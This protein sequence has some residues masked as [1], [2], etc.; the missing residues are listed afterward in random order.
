MPEPM[1]TDRTGTAVPARYVK[2][3]DKARDKL[4]RRIE[5]RW[6]E[7]Y[8][9]LQAVYA[10]TLSDIDRLAEL[11]GR[12]GAALGGAKGNLQ[13]QSFDG[14][15]EIGIDARYDIAF[16][17]RLRSAQEKI[18]AFIASKSEGID[19]ELRELVMAA[20]RPT[21]DGLLSR[22]RILGLLRLDI[23]AALWRE[24]MDLIRES[25][26]SRRGKTLLRVQRRAT[27]EAR[28]ERINLSM[29]DIAERPDATQA[30]P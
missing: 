1:M 29:S 17:E 24:A 3:Y 4:A 12:D 9:R 11:A 20:F 23:K 25:I 27:R 8:A 16:D 21:S 30:A 13:F 18:E 7:A 22:V 28:W 6:R 15:I 14:L 26:Q 10:E 19:A 5:R 2:P